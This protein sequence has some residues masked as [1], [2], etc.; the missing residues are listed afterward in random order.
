[1]I[2]GGGG[3]IGGGGGGTPDKTAWSSSE[4][5]TFINDLMNTTSG[6]G[7][8]ENISKCMEKNTEDKYSHIQFSKLPKNVKTTKFFTDLKNNCTIN[9]AYDAH[10]TRGSGGGGGNSL[11]TGAIIGIIAGSLLIIGGIIALYMSRKVE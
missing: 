7:L 9:P 5:S 6:P 8:T 3:M 11:S 1:M 10:N 2:G 4:K